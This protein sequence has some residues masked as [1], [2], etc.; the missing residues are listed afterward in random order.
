M[1]YDKQEGTR[2]LT[3][4]CLS[5]K[6]LGKEGVVLAA[7]KDIFFGDQQCKNNTYLLFWL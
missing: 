7:K 5:W 6:F 2:N 4:N 3:I 1:V